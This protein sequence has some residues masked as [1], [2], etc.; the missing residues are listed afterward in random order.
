ML[1]TAIKVSISHSGSEVAGLRALGQHATRV[2]RPSPQLDLLPGFAP[3][4]EHQ[5][6]LAATIDRLRLLHGAAIIRRAGD[7]PLPKTA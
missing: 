1:S 2:Y 5:L 3:Q 4:R 6:K 7:L